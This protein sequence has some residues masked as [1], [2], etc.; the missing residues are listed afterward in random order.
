MGLRR[1]LGYVKEPRGQLFDFFRRA[2]FYRGVSIPP[3][4][5]TFV[6]REPRLP[7]NGY[8]N[9]SKSIEFIVVNMRENGGLELWG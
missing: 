9:D 5:Y 8:N 1:H 4:R 3:I 7:R 6:I 2:C